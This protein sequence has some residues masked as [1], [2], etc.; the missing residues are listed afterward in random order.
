MIQNDKVYNHVSHL[1]NRL[2]DIII[3][4]YSMG[5]SGT[6]LVYVGLVIFW[7]L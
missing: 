7:Y 2:Y 4:S 6:T 5:V 1:T 3:E